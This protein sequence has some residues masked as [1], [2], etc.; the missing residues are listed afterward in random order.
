[1][2]KITEIVGAWASL[3]NPTPEEIARAEMRYEICTNCDSF[4]T[5]IDVELCGECGCVIKAKVFSK[6][7]E[8]SPCPLNK[9]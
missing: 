6:K 5:A 3:F 2:N 9:W 1:M 8:T 7:T 4:K